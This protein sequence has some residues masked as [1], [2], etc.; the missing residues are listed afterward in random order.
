MRHIE[1]SDTLLAL[2]GDISAGVQT[3][4]GIALALGRTV[5]LAHAPDQ[6]LAYFN[7]A[8]V[9]SAAGQEI[10]LQEKVDD[11]KQALAERLG[12]AV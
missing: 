11:M 4:V 5:F 8:I 9:Q 1:E 12:V 7:A 3:E 10:L 6:P 2:L